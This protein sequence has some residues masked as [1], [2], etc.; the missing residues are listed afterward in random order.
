MSYMLYA[1]GSSGPRAI[2]SVVL[3]LRPME[4]WDG[5]RLI[6]VSVL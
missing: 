4:S 5:D 1:S 6:T 2:G 3:S